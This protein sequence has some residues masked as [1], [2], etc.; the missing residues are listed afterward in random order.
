[1]NRIRT[2]ITKARV[3]LMRR[4]IPRHPQRVLFLC[5]GNT[6]RSPMAEN[7]HRYYGGPNVVVGSGMSY[8]GNPSPSPINDATINVLKRLGIVPEPE[9]REIAK[10][11]IVI[12]LDTPGSNSNYNRARERFGALAV[13]WPVPDPFGQGEAAYASTYERF[14]E[15]FATDLG[16]DLPPLPAK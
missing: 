4:G 16:V 13:Q 11:E 1:M 12:A 15:L 5:T 2:A 9:K 14:R 6:C 10:P 7:L 8:T 3:W